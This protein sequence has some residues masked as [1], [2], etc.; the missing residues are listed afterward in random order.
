MN[1]MTIYRNKDNELES[2]DTESDETLLEIN[3]EEIYKKKQF[4]W[5]MLLR[6]FFTWSLLIKMIGKNKK[7]CALNFDI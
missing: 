7:V 6:I 4:G 1:L 3:K 2:I 5:R